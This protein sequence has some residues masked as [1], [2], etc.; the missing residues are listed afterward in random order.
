MSRETLAVLMSAFACP[1]IGQLMLGRRRGWAFI[2]ASVVI[3]V[4]LFVCILLIFMYEVPM[5]SFY[6]ADSSEIVDIY[7]KVRGEAYEKGLPM[8]LTFLLVWLVNMADIMAI[9]RK[10]KS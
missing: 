4:A 8:L 9:K 7:L 6:V 1:G 2:T 5:E 10:E 3:V